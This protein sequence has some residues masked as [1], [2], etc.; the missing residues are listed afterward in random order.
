VLARILLAAFATVALLA[1]TVSVSPAANAA[2]AVP[3]MPTGLPSAIEKPTTYVRSYSCDMRTQPGT[4]ALASL[5]KTTYPSVSYGLNRTCTHAGEHSDG[6][7][8][9]W[10][11]TSANATTE[12]YAKAFI[13]W[14]LK[15]DAAGNTFANARRLGVMYVIHDGMIWGS[16]TPGNGWKEYNGCS[17]L[18]GKSYFNYCHR[19]HVH[20]SLSWEGARKQTSFWTKKVAATNFG[21]CRVDG[22]RW[23]GRYTA[24]RST[25]C[26][27]PVAV[28]AAASATSKQKALVDNSGQ[29][30]ELGDVGPGVAAVQAA[31]GVNPTGT[32][33]SVT[34]AAVL[35]FKRASSGVDANALIGTGTWKSLLSKYVPKAVYTAPSH[36]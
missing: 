26:P 14:L 7:A 35:K 25:P 31:L 4:Q 16:Y 22:L 11:A 23:A 13:A 17:T 8:I 28:T 29:R 15:T 12:G 24:A 36:R 9:D 27:Q 20:I 32:F 10:M 6:R 33:G 19:D 5:L 18:T 21:P 2:V 3:K 34:E 1:T 30:L